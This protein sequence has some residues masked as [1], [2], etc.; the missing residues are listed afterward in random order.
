[1]VSQGR[2]AARPQPV[3]RPSLTVPTMPRRYWG[4]LLE[5]GREGFYF[6]TVAGPAGDLPGVFQNLIL[7]P[8]WAQDKQPGW[9]KRTPGTGKRRKDL[10]QG[11][12]NSVFRPFRAPFYSHPY[13]GLAKSARPRL[14][15][16]GPSGATSLDGGFAA[17][18]AGRPYGFG[19]WQNYAALG[20]T[21]AVP[22][23]DPNACQRHGNIEPVD[24]RW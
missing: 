3:H 2:A 22:G 1:V 19:Q 16:L 7:R 11:R 12:T 23:W 8:G 14:I 20:G 9:A 24:R 10:R 21:P 15:V 17:A 13:R 4:I 5:S 6:Y 18:S